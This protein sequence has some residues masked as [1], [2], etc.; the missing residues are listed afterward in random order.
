[1]DRVLSDRVKGSSR[2]VRTV[3][4]ASGRMISG[5]AMKSVVE[6]SKK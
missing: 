5:E 4:T 6:K 2:R 1:M 3:V